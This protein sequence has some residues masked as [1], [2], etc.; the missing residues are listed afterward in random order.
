MRFLFLLAHPDDETVAGGGTMRLLAEAG[1]EV[2]VVLATSGQ[3][4]EVAA[5]AKA[6]LVKWGSI[7]KLRREELK[8]AC[9]VLGVKDY[10]I[11]DF[12][13]G[14]IT[15]RMVWGKLKAAFMGEIEAYKPDVVITFDHSGWY[16]H[17]DHVGVSIAALWAVREAK[18]K[19][20]T[21]AFNVFRPEGIAEKWP[22]VYSHS[23]PVTHRVD[24]RPVIQ[25]KRLALLAHKSQGLERLIK[26]VDRGKLEE[27]YFQAVYGE[28]IP[29]EIFEPVK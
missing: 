22:Y 3:A 16:F 14:E 12:V 29:Q 4:G 8:K 20:K 7:D 9:R 2:R 23:L 6:E 21:L 5:A 18:H 15:N 27:E 1:H 26:L 28:L 24:I 13:D 10:K 19:T 17:L 25:K 11:L